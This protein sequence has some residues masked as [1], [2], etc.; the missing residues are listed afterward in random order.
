MLKLEI[1]LYAVCDAGDYRGITVQEHNMKELGMLPTRGDP[2]L[3]ICRAQGEGDG[4]KIGVSD[5]YVGDGINAG[6]SD[7]ECNMEATLRHIVS[8]ESRTFL[9]TAKRK[10]VR[11]RRGPLS[12]TRDSISPT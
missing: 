6:T 3:Y 5:S 9:I 1:F 10:S 2:S 12:L 11:Q 8:R 7:F 4:Q